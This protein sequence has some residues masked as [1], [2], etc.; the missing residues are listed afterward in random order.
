MPARNTMVKPASSAK[1]QGGGMVK[2]RVSEMEEFTGPHE[3]PINTFANTLTHTHTA[4]FFTATS[5]FS[6]HYSQVSVVKGHA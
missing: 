3:D 5:H 4:A 2:C 1:G 6:A